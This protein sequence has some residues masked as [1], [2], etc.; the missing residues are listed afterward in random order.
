[1]TSKKELV[2]A[3]AIVPSP[4]VFFALALVLSS[5][6]LGYPAYVMVVGV[7]PLFTVMEGAALWLFIKNRPLSIGS[8]VGCVLAIGMVL[9]TSYVELLLLTARM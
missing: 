6:G 8:V 4:V 1:M 7:N 3:W 9:L 5:N 2:V